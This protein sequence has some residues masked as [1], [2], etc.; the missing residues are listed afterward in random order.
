MIKIENLSKEFTVYRRPIAMLKGVLGLAK[1]GKDYSIVKSLNKLNLDIPSA[2]VH[3]IIGM[4]GAGKST[5]LKILT[6]VLDPT[7]GHIKIEGKVAAL[8]ELGTGF[9]RELTGRENVYLSGPIMGFSDAELEAK[10]PEIMEFAELEDYF[11]RPLKTYSSGMYVRLAFSLAISVQ[12]DILIIDEALSV[13]DAYFQQKCLKKIKDFKEQGTTILF[14]SHDLSAVKMLCN[15]VSVL[16]KGQLI[17]TGEPLH[18]VDLYNALISEHRDEHVVA[19][20]TEQAKLSSADR[21]FESGSK[22]IEIKEIQI[23]NQKG[24]D[25][26]S[27]VSGT[28]VTL[29][30]KTLVNVKELF[31]PTCGILIRDRLGYDIFG[32]NTLGL[33]IKAG[34]VEQGKM[35]EFRFHFPLNLGPGSYSLSVSLHEGR[36]HI[37]E[38]YHWLERGKMFEVLPS[39]DMDFIGAARLQAQ[40]EVVLDKF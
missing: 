28:S 13:G 36:T 15:R 10:L 20:R 3:G 11:D 14:V 29:C 33:R 7:H 40:C 17:F 35:V 38:N 19:M 25:L 6:G 31:D 34:R 37:E 22:K 26:S 16:S 32:V 30:I 18:A 9:H 5:L 12:P 21:S 4:N 1:E 8:L 24:Q 23:L 2:E 39:A 27:V